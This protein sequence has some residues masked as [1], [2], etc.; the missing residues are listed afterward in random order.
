MLSQLEW[1]EIVEIVAQAVVPTLPAA[2]CSPQGAPSASVS[3]AIYPSPAARSST[4]IAAPFPPSTPNLPSATPAVASGFQRATARMSAGGRSPRRQEPPADPSPAARLSARSAAPVLP[5]APHIPSALPAVTGTPPVA[6]G[7]RQRTTARMSTGGRP[8]RRQEPSVA[9]SLAAASSARSAA[10]VLLS[11]PRIPSALPA[12][13]GAPPAATGRR[14]R[15]TA[16]MSTG[17]RPPRRQEPPVDPSL[18]APSS[19]RSAAPVLL[20]APR[21]PSALPAA[22]GTPPVATGRRQ[23]TTARMS[24]GGRPPRRQEPPVDPSLA[25]PSSARTA[26]S[27]S[28]P[29]PPGTPSA[30]TGA[31]PQRQRATATF[32]THIFDSDDELDTVSLA[33]SYQ[34]AASMMRH[35]TTISGSSLFRKTTFLQSSASPRK[36]QRAADWGDSLLHDDPPLIPLPELF[37]EGGNDLGAEFEFDE[38]HPPDKH[39]RRPRDTDRPLR[40]W[41]EEE[42]PTFVDELLRSAGR[43]DNTGSGFTPCNAC[44]KSDGTHRYKTTTFCIVHSNGIHEVNLDY[45]ECAGAPM[46]SVQLLRSKL[47]PATTL[48]PASAATFEVLRGYQL[49]SFETKC[50]AYEFYNALAR[51]TNNS[52]SFQP[53]DRYSQFLRMTREWAHIQMLKRFGRAHETAGCRNI[54]AGSCAV[55]CPAC[56]QPGK[57]LPQDGSWRAAPP[58]LR[59]LY[60]LFLAIDANFRMKRKAVSSEE[61]D[62]DLNQGCAFYSQIDEY[63]EHV[64]AHWD[65]EQEKSRC[66][67]H[68]AVNEPNREARGTASS[69]IGT[70]DCARHNMKRPNGVVDLQKGERYINM[71]YALWKSLDGYD[72]LVQ[73]VVSYDIVC[74]WSLNIWER[75]KRY[76]PCLQERARSGERFFLWLI[77]KF[78]LP[79]HIEACNVLYSFDLTPFVGRTDGEAP[80]RGW[81]NTNPLAAS[82]REMGPG[83]RRDHID[84]HFNDW[85]HKK[86]LGMG[87][88]LLKHMQ[89]AIPQMVNRSIE[90][91]DIEE[92][93]P[94]DTLA[95]WVTQMERWEKDASEP[96]PFAVGEKHASL[97]AVRG[98]IAAE[99]QAILAGDDSDEVRGDLHVAEMIAMGMQLG[100]QQRALASDVKALGI[101]ATARQKTLIQERGNKLWRKIASWF[102]TQATF[103]PEVTAIREADADKLAA[104]SRMDPLPPAPAFTARLWLPSELVGES[105]C[106]VKHA[107]ARYEFDMREARAHEC[108]DELR[109]LLLV[110]KHHYQAKDRHAFGVAANTRAKESLDNIQRR[111]KRTAEEYRAARAALVALARLLGDAAWSRI[112]RPLE[113]K[114]IRGMPQ[115]LFADPQRK[116][117]KKRTLQTVEEREAETLAKEM[118]WIWRTSLKPVAEVASSSQNPETDSTSLS[119]AVAEHEAQLLTAG[120]RVE[121]AKARARAGRWREEVDLLEEEMRRVLAFEE[122]RAAWWRERRLGREAEELGPAMD[123]AL[124]A[125]AEK[126]ARFHDRRAGKLRHMWKSVPGSIETGRKGVVS[127]VEA[128][129]AE[130]DLAIDLDVDR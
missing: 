54:P 56:P 68:D 23:R 62:P 66:V 114:D 28:A 59:F 97:Q 8:P 108:L 43:G 4:Q 36:R 98:R 61:V 45:C 107:F 19:A 120:L 64:R 9:P 90:L 53:R 78:H 113:E 83:S 109:R 63:M 128:S 99:T 130:E 57:N 30:E 72:E 48:R 32:S 122:W 69:G 105:R 20:S 42:M 33:R 18:A 71:D 110:Q 85:N 31:L 115:A 34:P 88:L 100:E 119:P 129:D 16:R 37:N 27:S 127:T 103:I 5:S 25:A 121:W 29:N 10:P 12:A 24:T 2:G 116:Q 3:P 73:L 87:Q 91:R 96:N 123:E 104:A 26:A 55:L 50:S 95:S 118:S 125:Y 86:V 81:S 89:D 52:G 65:T 101:H 74:Q 82:T 79:A 35:D 67:S 84:N 102:A 94:Q 111:I 70:V 44:K 93:L 76:K 124:H 92:S 17:G 75:L 11:A 51:M 117:K 40:I 1:H 14:Q 46:H 39:P 47:Y 13:T 80:E 106:T 58:H 112:L 38:G 60:A 41:L 22:T 6:T 21:I 126:Q 77:P 7:R 15:T 49:L